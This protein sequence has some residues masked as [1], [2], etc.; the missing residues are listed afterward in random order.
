MNID[1]AK[2]RLENT[3]L[4]LLLLEHKTHINKLVSER[5]HDV[6]TQLEEAIRAAE[7]AQVAQAGDAGAV[8]SGASVVSG[9]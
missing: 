6:A 3:R 2:A 7:G 5:L 9:D 4:Q 8:D 1:L